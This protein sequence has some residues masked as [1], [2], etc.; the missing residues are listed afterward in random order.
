MPLPSI[1]IL[2][3]DDVRACLP[4][5]DC[6]D[7]MERALAAASAGEALVPLR[8]TLWLSD[9]RGLLG[10]MPSIDER[11]ARAGAKII[12]VLPG[13]HGTAFDAHQGAVLLFET[14]QGRLEAILDASALTEIRTAAA[15]GAATRRL[16][17]P[18]AGDLAILGSGVQARAHLA[19]M[20]AVRPLRRVRVWSRDPDRARAFAARES[21]RHGLAV[22]PVASAREAVRGADLVCTTTSSP[23]PVLEGAWL[24]PGA[25]V[26]AV[27]ACIPAMRELDTEAVRR[28][29][30]L[31]DRRE[32]ALAE[33]GDVL[34][35]IREGAIGS[36]HVAG[37]VGEVF[38]GMIAGRTGDGEITL[39]KSL[40]IA[41]ED[42]AAA[43]VAVRNATAA[44]RGAVVPFGGTR[45]DAD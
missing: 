23:Q 8:S 32:S 17:R 45:D 34:I 16:A 31:V 20:R 39:F 19:A 21:A 15:S 33:A 4:M 10:V 7:A 9:R 22:E 30:L 14:R 25:H 28:A 29:R 43:D 2:S 37:E 24:A 1:R 35:P 18:D 13:N 36:D 3:R 42:L 12:T 5:A 44:G 41:I 27:G 26:N 11:A 38:L 40:G 6:I